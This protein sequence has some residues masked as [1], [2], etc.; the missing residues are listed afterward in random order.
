MHEDDGQVT[1]DLDAVSEPLALAQRTGEALH[2]VGTRDHEQPVGGV[3]RSEHRDV[4]GQ[5]LAPGT[6]VRVRMAAKRRAG[7]PGGV[8]E[9]GARGRVVGREPHDATASPAAVTACQTPPI[10][11]PL[12][13]PG[14]ASPVNP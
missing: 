14:D 8:E 1:G 13:S 11:L 12:V 4:G 10:P 5:C 6:G 7:G 9:R 2:P 3:G